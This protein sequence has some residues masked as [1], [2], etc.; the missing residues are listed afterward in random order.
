MRCS[1]NLNQLFKCR[2]G[3][4]DS[5]VCCSKVDGRADVLKRLTSEVSLRKG[6]RKMQVLS[7]EEIYQVSGASPG[8]AAV[9]TIAGGVAGYF[10]GGTVGMYAGAAIGSVFGP[11]GTIAGAFIGRAVGNQFGGLVVGS[12]GG[13]IGDKFSSMQ[14]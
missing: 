5:P 4:G 12:F 1:L 10:A 13:W 8:G 3:G 11:G 6:G 2:A 9:G 14:K 7:T